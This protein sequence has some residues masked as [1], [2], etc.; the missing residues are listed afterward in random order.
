MGALFVAQAVIAACISAAFLFASRRYVIQ[1]H[2]RAIPGPPSGSLWAGNLKEMFNHNASPFHDKMNNL[3]GKVIRISGAFGDSQLVISDTKALYNILIKEQYTFEETSWFIETNRLVFGPGLLST[4][5]ATHRKQRKILNPAFSINH[6]RRMIPM[7][8]SITMELQNIFRKEL[9]DGA[10]EIDMLEWM[11]KL[12][13]EL[14]AQAGLG[15]TFKALQG[16]NN[17]YANALKSFVFVASHPMSRRWRPCK[18]GAGG[19]RT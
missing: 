9:A 6:M 11:G 19:F 15:Y 7:F 1:R 14:I 4:L 2:L 10:K 17:D 8:Q 16:E 12:A 3:Y 5:G 13:L 18:C